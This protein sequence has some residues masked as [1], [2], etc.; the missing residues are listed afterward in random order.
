MPR[1]IPEQKPNK[2]KRVDIKLNNF[3]KGLNTLVAPAQIRV[4]E[5][6]E[7]KNIVFQNEGAPSRRAGLDTY[8]NSSGGTATW[9]LTAYYPSNGDS[10]LLKLED[11]ILKKLLNTNNWQDITGASFTTGKVTDSTQLNDILYITNDSDALTKYDGSSLTTFSGISSP[12]SASATKGASLVSGNKQLN[13]LV[14][15]ENDVGE[16]TTAAIASYINVDVERSL[17]NPAA[18]LDDNKSVEVTWSTVTGASGYNIYVGAPGDELYVHTAKGETTDSWV[19]YGINTPSQ[20][21]PAPLADTTTA[22]NGAIVERFKTAL[23]IAGGDPSRVWF[24]AGVD[25]PDSF[26]FGAGGGFVDISKNSDDGDITGIKSYQNNAIIFKERSIWK[27]DFTQGAFPSVSNIIQNTGCVAPRTVVQVENDLFF[28]GRKP[29]RGAAIYVLGNEPNYLNVLRTNELT[30]RVRSIMESI[31]S[32]HYDKCHAIYWGNKYILFY[33]AGSSTIADSALVYDR[34]RVGF[35]QWENFYSNDSVI[36]YD[37]NGK[38][39]FLMVDGND[40]RVTEYSDE[41]TTDKGTPIEWAFRTKEVDLEDPLLYKRFRWLDMR[42]RDVA[43]EITTEVITPKTTIRYTKQINSISLRT[44]YGHV[45]HGKTTDGSTG[46]G[47]TVDKAQGDVQRTIARR[48]P[49]KREGRNSV[50]RAVSLRLS[51]KKAESK[52]KLLDVYIEA[53]PRSR[54]YYDVNEVITR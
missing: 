4:D 28:L 1:P 18:T 41:Y 43:G 24:S 52:L 17:W 33:P 35:V 13:Y 51:G 22:P 27:F 23:L 53:D 7:A 11:G 12:G 3:G 54:E 20:F 44:F 2:P 10:E 5:L 30:A 38:E 15:A 40:N 48:I 46:F 21:K 8:A 9:L 49:L 14:S 37:S 32:A 39:H 26:N 36:F 31:N 25:K 45:K 47:S 42:L 34:E 50:A 6:A 19:D 16:T 29:G